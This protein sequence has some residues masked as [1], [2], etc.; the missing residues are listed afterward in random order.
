ML[1]V[2]EGGAAD[3]SAACWH[4]LLM[5]AVT[6]TELLVSSYQT[7]RRYVSEHRNISIKG[8]GRFISESFTFAVIIQ[9]CKAGGQYMY[10]QF[11]VQQFYVLSTQ[12]DCMFCVDLRTNS[13]Y[14]T[15]QH[16]LVFITETEC[17]YCAVRSTFY[18][19]PTQCVYVFCV[20]LRTN[21]DYFTV[22]H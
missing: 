15:V 1:A 14:F 17:V 10:Y 4:I 7:I 16:W 19:L 21:N 9:P 6:S 12:C 8:S 22:Q 18:V 13:D 3:L 11:N 20:D 2:M 5:E